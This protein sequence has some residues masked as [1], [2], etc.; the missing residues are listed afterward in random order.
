MK[1]FLKANDFD[2]DQVKIVEKFH[3][4]VKFFALNK[5]LGNVTKT[6]NKL[7]IYHMVNIFHALEE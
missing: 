6:Y 4:P 2:E 3:Q 1:K 5:K 7:Y